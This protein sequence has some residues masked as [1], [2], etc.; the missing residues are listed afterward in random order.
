VSNET[1]GNVANVVES[2]VTLKKMS[3]PTGNV[4]ALKLMMMELTVE[5]MQLFSNLSNICMNTIS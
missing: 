3:K 4:P 5:R 1:D 2:Y